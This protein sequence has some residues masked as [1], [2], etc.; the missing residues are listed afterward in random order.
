MQVNEVKRRL[1]SC[2]L[3]ALLSGC[4]QQTEPHSATFFAMDTVMELAVYG[5]ES[6]LAEGE[7]LI[8]DIEQRLSVTDSSSEI[9]ELNRN[10]KAAC[11]VRKD[12]WRIG[13]YRLS[14]SAGLGLYYRR[15]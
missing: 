5:S 9:A 4:G 13:Y 3:M 11:S 6:L 10:G 8:L 12:R 2:V 7:E 14:G 1:L 15:V